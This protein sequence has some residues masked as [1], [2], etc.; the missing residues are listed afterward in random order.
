MDISGLIPSHPGAASGLA[1]PNSNTLRRDSAAGQTGARL[2]RR[3][4]EPVDILDQLNRRGGGEGAEGPENT[5]PPATRSA[6]GAVLSQAIRS[7]FD[8]IKDDL[9]NMFKTLNMGAEKAKEATNTLIASMEKAA[10]SADAFRFNFSRAVARY[11]RSEFA[12]SGTGGTG[13][14]ISESASLKIK[15]LDIYVNNKTGQFAINYKEA[16]VFVAQSAIATP[17][18]NEGVSRP[19]GFPGLSFGGGDGD[20]GISRFI[21]RLLQPA[22]GNSA[23]GEKAGTGEKP[24]QSAN[25]S[26]KAALSLSQQLLQAAEAVITAFEPDVADP[27]GGSDRFSRLRLDLSIPLGLLQRD[28]QGPVF[29]DTRG[30]RSQLPAPQQA[31]IAVDA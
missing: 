29:E 18:G 22:T 10:A 11:A 12:Y 4:Q 7:A 9:L 13:A 21:D 15:S 2:L 19:G 1:G 24:A 27:G 8:L 6:P 26:Q 28:K 23:A 25:P 3:A 30:H 16:S 17:S 14:G 31:G 20:N 5:K